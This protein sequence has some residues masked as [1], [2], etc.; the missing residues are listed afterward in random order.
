MQVSTL[1]MTMAAAGL[2]AGTASAQVT[3]AS[4]TFD[5]LAG[6]Y[7]PTTPNTGLFTARAVDT[8]TLRTVGSF[9]RNNNASSAQFSAGFVSGPDVADVLVTMNVTRINATTATAVGMVVVTDI[10]GDVFRSPVSGVWS[11]NLTG[12]GFGGSMTAPVFDSTTGNGIIEG[13]TGGWT[14]NFGSGPLSGVLTLIVLNANATFFT[15]AYSGEAVGSAAQIVPGPA[16]LA[17]AGLAAGMAGRRRRRECG[18][19][20]NEAEP[21]LR[22]C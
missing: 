12:A 11:K 8:A 22:A 5:S 19:A 21:Q 16:A 18:M 17:V 9:N 2:L 1:I 10:N 20:R 15:T 7:V 6:S 4:F 13:N 14:P 3:V